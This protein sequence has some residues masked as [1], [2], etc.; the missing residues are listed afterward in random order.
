MSFAD[1]KEEID[2]L[3]EEGKYPEVRNGKFWKK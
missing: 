2:Q 1:K 3:Y